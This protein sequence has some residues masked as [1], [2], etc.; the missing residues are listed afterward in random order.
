MLPFGCSCEKRNVTFACAA[1]TR[2]VA[3]TTGPSTATAPPIA[4]RESNARLVTSS[5]FCRP[6]PERLASPRVPAASRIRDCVRPIAIPPPP[7][8]MLQPFPAQLRNDAPAVGAPGMDF[9][10]SAQKPTNLVVHQP[11]QLV[12]TD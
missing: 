2:G 10:R 6:P 4:S 1:R 5:R 12:L 9:P 11:D 7:A 8:V 3:H